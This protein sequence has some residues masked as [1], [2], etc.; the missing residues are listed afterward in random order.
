MRLDVFDRWGAYLFTL[1]PLDLIEAEWTDE[2]EDAD[3][4][5]ITTDKHLYKGYRIVWRDLHNLMHEHI[6]D[7]SDAYDEAADTYTCLNSICELYGDYFDDAVGNVTALTAITN[8]LSSTRWRVGVVD[9]DGTNEESFY[10]E[11]VRECIAKVQGTWGG[12]LST[13]I[14]VSGDEIIGRYV[15]LQAMRGQDRGKRF[16]YT[17]DLE[18]VAR[19]I[20][21][22]DVITR[23]YGYGKGQDLVDG[24]Y[25]SQLDFA[26]INGG[27]KYVE[28]ADLLGTWGKPGK[29]GAK[30]HYEGVINFD[31]VEDKAELLKLTKQALSQVCEPKVTYEADVIDLESLGFEHEA[32][33]VGDVVAIID[34][35][36][37]PEIRVQGRVTKI[38]RDLLSEKAVVTVGNVVAQTSSMLG[39]NSAE[40]T[41]ITAKAKQ[42]ESASQAALALT[43]GELVLQAESSSL[44]ATGE[45]VAIRDADGVV[46]AGLQLAEDHASLISGGLSGALGDW[47][48]QRSTGQV[49]VSNAALTWNVTQWASGQVDAVS[50]IRNETAQATVAIPWPQELATLTAAYAGGAELTAVDTAARTATF[51]AVGGPACY[52]LTGRRADG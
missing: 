13:T 48:A 42:W 16:V 41:T 36:H 44:R 30:K 11:S 46:M 29:D 20:E 7:S 26:S 18:G 1:G 28:R 25:Q 6:V 10:H 24:V 38:V 17:K 47:V 35:V 43:S 3:V 39:T 22:D 50:A 52:V 5:T 32:V 51:K 37:D 19:V 8:L 4:L 45:E 21:S 14:E 31:Q 33:E 40:I 27:K 23:L 15:N 2:L 9:V 34:K 12:E 49:T